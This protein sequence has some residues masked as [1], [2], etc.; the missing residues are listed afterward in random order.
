MKKVKVEGK[1]KQHAVLVYALS[2]CAWCKMTKKHLKENGIEYEYI[3]VD[4][5][6]D[7]DHE[8]IRKHII[9]K[10]GEPIYPTIIVDDKIVITGFRKDK[11]K[12][13]LGV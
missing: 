7:D 8:K 12:E 3:D 11:I 1:N 6:S 2:T 5:A 4:L 10:G 13:A 9:S